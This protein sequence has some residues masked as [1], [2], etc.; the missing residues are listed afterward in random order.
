M[1]DF[2]LEDSYPGQIVAGTD[3]AGRGPLAGP[4]IAAAVIL[5]R[6]LPDTLLGLDDSKKLSTARRETLAAVITQC[7]DWAVAGASAA[8]IDQLNILR[9]SLLAMRRATERLKNNPAVLLVDGKFAPDV[10]F[11]TQCVIKGDSRSL[12]IAAAS[13]LA[14]VRRDQIMCRYDAM[15]PGYGFERHA[16]YPTKAHRAAIIARGILPIHRRSFRLIS[17][18]SVTIT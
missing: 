8:E 10:S 18:E 4:V 3:E 13:I 7:A 6:P 14:K 15:Y 12:S 2:S 9:A 16:G 5:P 17:Q 1:A 11:K